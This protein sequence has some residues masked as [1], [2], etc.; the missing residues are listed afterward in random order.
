MLSL[1][2]GKFTTAHLTVEEGVKRIFAKAKIARKV[3]TL[4]KRL[5]PGAVGHERAI[6]EFAE[7]AL[8]RGVPEAVWQGA[9]GRLGGLVRY[10]QQKPEY[11]EVFAGQILRGEVELARILEQAYSVEDLVRRRLHAE[12][13]PKKARMIA[14]SLIEGGFLNDGDCYIVNLT[15]RFADAV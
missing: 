5:L 15:E 13:D 11:F 9:A 4:R 14:Q 12:Y 8:A 2:G 7:A 6:A 1:F 10:F 3:V